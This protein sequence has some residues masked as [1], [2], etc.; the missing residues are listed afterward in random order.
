MKKPFNPLFWHFTNEH[1]KGKHYLK[2]VDYIA[3]NLDIDYL[4]VSTLDGIVLGNTE[5]CHPV[6]KEV[7]ER[8]HSH[9]IGFGIRLESYK[10][11]FNA[12][13]FG[14]KFP[15]PYDQ[16]ELFPI[17][18]PKKAEAIIN[19]YE[20]ELDQDGY[21]EVTHCAKWGR[22]KIMP[23][24]NRVIKI[25]VFE[26]AGEGFYK[27]G[28]LEDVTDKCLITESRTNKMVV[29]VTL[30][31]EYAGKTAFF[32]IAQY[33]NSVAVSDAVE[34][35]LALIDA[36]AD[37]GLDGI[38]MDEYGYLV[39]NTSNIEAG[40]EEPFRGRIYSDSMKKYYAETW[41]LDLDRLLF[42]MRYAPQNDEKIRIKAINT[43]FEKLRVFPLIVENR[44]AEYC[45]EKF[46]D[47][48]YISC[49]NTF[50][51][52]LD[53]DDIWHTACNWWDL[54]REWGHTD[55]NITFPVR[56]GVMLA[57]KNPIMIDMYY[58]AENQAY[59]DHIIDGAPLHCRDFHHAYGDFFWGGSYT[60][61]QFLANI[62]KL[63]KQIK[64]LNDF[65]SIYPRMDALI[66]FG[67]A[68]QF[69]WYPDYEA[70][71]LWDIDDKMKIQDKCDTMWK[72]GYRV[73]LVPDYAIEDGRIT[74]KDGKVCFGGYEFSH[75]LFLYPKYA[76]QSTYEFLNSAFENGV[77]VA[78]VGRSDINFNGE[79][80]ELKIPT[81]REFD[82]SILEKMGCQKSGI[83]G[84]AVYDDGSFN[85]VS[86]GILT[87]QESAFDLVVAGVRYTGTHTG[88][89][90]YRK[91]EFAFATKGS[92]L[93]ADGIE[94]PLDFGQE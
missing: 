28:T 38:I 1:L 6:L 65:Q 90:A 55:E 8:C 91:G 32:E 3:G 54:P 74:L 92:R 85:L 34:H 36:Y 47:N 37:I 78:A 68:A 67:A 87:D 62:R 88:L 46:G 24:Y 14:G 7:A 49:H 5:Q 69:N 42:D 73:A 45:K 80:A 94:I 22:V 18:D 44:V 39:L 59:Y 9:G 21:G 16:V 12:N 83:E 33:Y 77:A 25:Y 66:V 29:D 79:K 48:F 57:A 31:S 15:P 76:K 4:S 41:K 58:S 19:D 27:K 40:T 20:V 63:D 71:N 50:H 30:G 61:P 70:R 23:I 75:C 84:G 43:Y 2:D 56:W 35:H 93:F 11:F 60:D 72:D 81:Y 53:G 26:K 13:I 86:G 52:H 10:G 17:P 89:L 82:L 51:N 64:R